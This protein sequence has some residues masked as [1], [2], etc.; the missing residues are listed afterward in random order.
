MTTVSE[1]T[2][3]YIAGRT[4]WDI[5]VKQL[6]E[7]HQEEFDLLKDAAEVALELKD[8]ISDYL[9]FRDD[10]IYIHSPINGTLTF[11]DGDDTNE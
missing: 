1:W 3:T 9:R 7:N 2:T 8:E 10:T 6:I 4:P 5:A 11:H